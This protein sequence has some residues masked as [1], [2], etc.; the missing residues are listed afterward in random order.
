MTGANMTD[1]YRILEVPPGASQ[2]EIKTR[3]K[4]LVRIYHPDRYVDPVDKSFV[5][6]KLKEIN[7][8]YNALTNPDRDW[9]MRSRNVALPQP[10]VLPPDGLNFGKMRQGGK[11]T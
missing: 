3:Y 2:E 7:E 4:Q 1:Y 5:E 10:V 8:A 9:F 6:Q 11:Q